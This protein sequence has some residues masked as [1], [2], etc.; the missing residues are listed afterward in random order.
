MTTVSL[1]KVAFTWKGSYD[2]STTYNS[3]DVVEYNGDSFVCVTD[4]TSGTAPTST[5][6]TTSPTTSNLTVT[7]QQYYG[8]NYFYIDGVKTPT[9]QLYEGNT[10]VF[11]VSDSSVANHPFK[12]STVSGGTHN[13]GTEYTTGVTVVGTHGTFGAYTKITVAI[14]APTLYYYCSNHSNMGGQLNTA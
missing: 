8:S 1:G 3:Q 10:Y 2:A 12:F 4:N 7:V 11:D 14:G 5:S 6:S 13:S 9:L